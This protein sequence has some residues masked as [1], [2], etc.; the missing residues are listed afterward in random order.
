MQNQQMFHSPLFTQTKELEPKCLVSSPYCLSIH[1]AWRHL[2]CVSL[3]LEFQTIHTALFVYTYCMETSFLRF[4][5]P[6]SFTTIPDFDQ[7]HLLV[8]RKA[9]P[10]YLKNKPQYIYLVRYWGSKRSFGAHPKKMKMNYLLVKPH[11]EHQL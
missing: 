1:I 2:F 3:F 9:K 7:T 6:F 5:F 4:Y 11:D 10:K 8:L